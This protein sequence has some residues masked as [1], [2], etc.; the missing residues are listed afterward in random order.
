[1]APRGKELSK[2]QIFFFVALRKDGVG[3][4]KIAKTLKL[5]KPCSGLT[6]QVPLRTGLAMVDQRS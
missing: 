5:P 3:H 1:M 6:G 2:D 4:K